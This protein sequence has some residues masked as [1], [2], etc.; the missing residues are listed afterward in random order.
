M[1]CSVL[2]SQPARDTHSG[3]QNRA[4]NVSTSPYLC[5]C[6]KNEEH[7]FA[8]HLPL[9]QIKVFANFI[10]KINHQ[11]ISQLN[12]ISPETHHMFRLTRSIIRCVQTSWDTTGRIPFK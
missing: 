8:I 12:Y 5:N 10:D 11:M 1:Q 7:E 6:M 2:L 4:P 9:P 3:H